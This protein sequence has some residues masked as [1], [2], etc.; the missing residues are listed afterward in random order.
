MSSSLKL[1]RVAVAAALAV[2]MSTTALANTTTSS[3]RGKVMKKNY[4]ETLTQLL[5]IKTDYKRS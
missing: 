5:H 2:G 3:I 4:D 1:M